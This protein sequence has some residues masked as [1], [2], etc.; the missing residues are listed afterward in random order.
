MSNPFTG[1]L[2]INIRHNVLFS[3]LVGNLR[4]TVVGPNTNVQFWERSGKMATFSVF[5]GPRVA[6][7]SG[8][9]SRAKAKAP[10]AMSREELI[11][12]VNRLRVCCPPVTEISYDALKQMMAD[13]KRM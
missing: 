8:I 5:G 2:L 3:F 13:R 6:V 1:P 10:E 12:E 9:D 4:L 11:Q 7:S